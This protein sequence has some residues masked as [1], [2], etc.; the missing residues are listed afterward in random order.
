VSN[1][2]SVAFTNGTLTSGGTYDTN[3]TFTGIYYTQGGGTFVNN[4]T[5]YLY[6]GSTIGSN[7]AYQAGNTAT[8]T[9]NGILYVG[10]TAAP[11]QLT[12]Y[13]NYVQSSSGT[14]NIA[15]IPA[16]ASTTSAGTNYS[17]LYTTGTATLSG[18]LNVN[19]TAGFYKDGTTFNV[20]DA[21]KGITNN[22]A[23]FTVNSGSPPIFLNFTS[24]GVQTVSGTEQAYQVEV[25]HNGYASTMTS[26]GGSANQIAVA[27][28]FDYKNSAKTTGLLATA[29]ANPAGDE[30]TLLGQLDVLDLNDAKVA[31]NTL[32]PE[33]YLAYASAL[34]DQANAFARQVDLRM[35][36]QN[37]KH[38]EDGW[39]FNFLG[40]FDTASTASTTGGYRTRDHLFGVYAGYDL[41]G[42]H[43]VI[44]IAASI[45]WDSLH[46]AL[47][48]LTGTNRDFAF[49]VYGAQ[50]FGA[51]RLSGQLAYN[52]GHMSATHTT[53][54]GDYTRTGKGK[55]GENMFKATAQLGYDVKLGGYKLEP[56]VGID[57]NKGQVNSFTETDAGAANLTVGAIKADRTE[58]LFGASVNR[59]HGV[60]RPYL[61]AL[62]REKISG[63]DATT[64]SAYLDGDNST[65][66]SVNGLGLGKGEF[67]ANA[68][69][70]W[71]F[72][73]AG[74]LFVGYQG[75]Y[76][77]SYQSHGISLGLRLEF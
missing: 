40:A 36:D 28:A 5:A 61:K 38:P 55:A 75:T 73:D 41:S 1:S 20:V 50:N 76:R 60:F 54:L 69:I 67:D 16:G 31:L 49:A 56:F 71:V 43:H 8:V 62:Y 32:S 22:G 15:I 52:L 72:D 77:S 9:N 14:L 13:G 59:D 45:S 7:L 6:T 27:G 33:G 74:A 30:A 48:S 24:L 21:L 64:V 37:S 51:L 23:T 44:G 10:T 18:T 2:D 26:L 11:A 42:P 19:V 29:N 58:A 3:T 4:G 35:T 70:N 34:R 46:Y 39:W 65:A 12:I 25:T 66:F 47:N 63:S 57:F 68:G 53:T 17:Q